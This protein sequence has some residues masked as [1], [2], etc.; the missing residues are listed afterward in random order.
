MKWV[1]ISGTWAKTTPEVEAEVRR[2][3]REIISRGD[4]IVS[5]GALGVDWIATDEAL[6]HDPKGERVKMIIPSS[7]ETYRKHLLSLELTGVPIAW[8]QACMLIEQMD[9]LYIR[10]PD[11]LIEMNHP[12]CT[13]EAY[14]DR[15]SKVLEH[16]QQLNAYQI[17]GSSG[18][19]DTINKA[20]TLG[21]PVT[22]RSY[23]IMEQNSAMAR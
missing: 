10:N 18:T 9:E 16:S 13:Q 6:K 4:G 2:D 20:K 5:G 21:M 23:S 7:A 3:V 15:N 17:N 19:Q 22:H 1:A 11:A 14:N 12:E 8:Q